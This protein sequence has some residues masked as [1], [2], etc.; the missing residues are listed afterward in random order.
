MINFEAKKLTR[1]KAGCIQEVHFPLS[2]SFDHVALVPIQVWQ[3]PLSR[4]CP[5]RGDADRDGIEC[6]WA[7]A[8]VVHFPAVRSIQ[9]QTW[10]IHS[11]GGNCRASVP[12][13]KY[14]ECHN[15][16]TRSICQISSQSLRPL[17]LEWSHWFRYSCPTS[18]STFR[19]WFCKSY[20]H[21][22]WLSILHNC[23]RISLPWIGYEHRLLSYSTCN[24]NWRIWVERLRFQREWS[25]LT[26]PKICFSLAYLRICQRWLDE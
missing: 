20:Y 7:E 5:P 8:M 4:C 25:P 13:S 9:L 26:C 6:R 24:D 3:S 16:V 18:R 2:A 21:C 22:P 19:T 12:I 11:S 14:I 17:D 1:T 15:W 10:W 23:P